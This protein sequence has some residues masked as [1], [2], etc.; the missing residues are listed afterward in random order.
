M[1]SSGPSPGVSAGVLLFGA[2]FATQQAWHLCEDSRI[3]F[4]NKRYPSTIV[5][6]IYSLEETARAQALFDFAGKAETGK[7]V[8]V[9]DINRALSDHRTKLGRVASTAFTFARGWQGDMPLRGTRQSK[10]LMAEQERAMAVGI[11]GFNNHAHLTRLRAL[12]VDVS[13][14]GKRWNQP[15]RL[16]S[17]K[18][19]RLAANGWYREAWRAYVA[20]LETTRQWGEDSPISRIRKRHNDLPR[21][22]SPTY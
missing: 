15:H 3:L 13:D 17:V 19:G 10:E 21:I 20:F 8:T 14:D 12:H 22:P 2:H 11:A 7:P 6:A 4:E 1:K 9:R 16:D 5:L 18:E